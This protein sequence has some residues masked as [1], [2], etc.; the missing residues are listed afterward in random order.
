M[1]LKVVF[2]NN[3]LKSLLNEKEKEFIFKLKPLVLRIKIKKIKL[4]EI[5]IEMIAKAIMKITT[6]K[7]LF[8]N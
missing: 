5:N 3:K 7:W 2:F 8:T 1:E 4:Y 6:T